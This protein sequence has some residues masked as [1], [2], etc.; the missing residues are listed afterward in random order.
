MGHRH[1]ICSIGKL[2]KKM[3]GQIERRRKNCSKNMGHRHGISSVGN[4]H[5]NL[6]D[7]IE[8]KKSEGT[9]PRPAHSS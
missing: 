7:Q 3:L 1:G 4:L 6:L 2:H 8:I 9:T 5:N